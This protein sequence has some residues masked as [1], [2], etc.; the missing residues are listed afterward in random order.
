MAG[1]FLVLEG[2]EGGGKS[3]LARGLAARMRAVGIEPV[4]VREPGGTPAAEALRS[5]LLR[6]D[7]HWAAE[8]ELLYF[9]AARADLVAEVIRPALDEDRVVVADR[10]D[11]ST[12]AYQVGG[13]G[14]PAP[15]VEW[16]NHAATGGLSP[17][18][19]LVLDVPPEVGVER[20]IAG[21]KQRDRLD[22]ESEDFHRRV[23]AV[24]LAAAGPTVVHLDATQPP[25]VLGDAAWRALENARGDLF[26]ARRS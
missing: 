25:A 20:Q 23:R 15:Q 2:P 13:R 26:G 7:R 17:D 21:G 11:L 5:A 8:T 4:E 12:Q 10:F 19:T 6:D 16:I 3:T 14:L 24:Y 9:A 18:L 1:F 22:R